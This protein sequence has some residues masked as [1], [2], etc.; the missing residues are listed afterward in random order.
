MFA[1]AAVR[2]H[3]GLCRGRPR[4]SR[5]RSTSAVCAVAALGA[6]IPRTPALPTAA[7]ETY[8]AHCT[9]TPAVQFNTVYLTPCTAVPSFNF[10]AASDKRSSL[11]VI[12]RWDRIALAASKDSWTSRR[13]TMESSSRSEALGGLRGPDGEA[14]GRCTC[15]T[16][17]SW[18][19]AERRTPRTTTPRPSDRG[20][21]RWQVGRCR[22]S[23]S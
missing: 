13:S 7:V 3:R 23:P 11:G 6:G 18:M 20:R 16:F 1:P 5:E 4:C 8:T 19:E 12:A 17:A 15:T 9:A 22:R 14:N 2:S 21:L 10:G